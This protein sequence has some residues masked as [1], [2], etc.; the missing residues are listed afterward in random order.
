MQIHDFNQPN[1]RDVDLQIG[2]MRKIFE[3]FQTGLSNIRRN[4]SRELDTGLSNKKRIRWYCAHGL[5][6][7]TF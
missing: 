7:P 4:K 6:R 3:S 1:H 2:K 5:A